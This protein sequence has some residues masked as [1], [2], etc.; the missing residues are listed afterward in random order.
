MHPW[1]LSECDQRERDI[2]ALAEPPHANYVALRCRGPQ[3]QR[4]GAKV[5]LNGYIMTTQTGIGSQLIF[6]RY[7]IQILHPPFTT[8][9]LIPF[10]TGSQANVVPP[11]NEW[12][13]SIPTPYSS[14]YLSAKADSIT[15]LKKNENG[16]MDTQ[17]TSL[18]LK[19]YGR[20]SHAIN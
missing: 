9:L 12:W 13:S 7:Y 19:W 11:R 1:P 8:H 17:T 10:S 4:R 20:F 6:I 14:N 3:G 2:S 16:T 15:S 18:D 5:G